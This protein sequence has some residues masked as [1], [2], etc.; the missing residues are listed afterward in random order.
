MNENSFSHT[1]TPHT[2]NGCDMWIFVCRLL[3]NTCMCHHDICQEREKTLIV[4]R[5]HIMPSVS[6]TIGLILTFM[7]MIKTKI[8][9]KK[10]HTFMM[11]WGY[12]FRINCEFLLCPSHSNPSHSIFFAFAFFSAHI[13]KQYGNVN[14]PFNCAHVDWCDFWAKWEWETWRFFLIWII[15]KEME[16]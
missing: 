8:F 15:L 12:K 13:Q 5:Y 16:E 1:H 11:A 4:L 7:R 6:F 14:W 2:G 10:K 3:E 9:Y